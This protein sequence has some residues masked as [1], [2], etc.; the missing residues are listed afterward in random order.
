[1]YDKQCVPYQL[2]TCHLLVILIVVV[3]I[4]LSGRSD[5]H[6]AW[7]KW[8][9]LNFVAVD[10]QVQALPGPQSCIADIFEPTDLLP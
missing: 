8:P 1:M 9:V 5:L 4:R 7:P 10:E 6:H 3:I 2:T